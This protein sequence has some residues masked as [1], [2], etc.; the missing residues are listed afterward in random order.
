MQ[1]SAIFPRV[2]LGEV[3]AA[4]NGALERHFP[5]GCGVRIIAEPGRSDYFAQV[6][7]VPCIVSNSSRFRHLCKDNTE[8]CKVDFILGAKHCLAI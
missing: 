7:H 6:G 4:V 8:V 2:D 3:P 5:P 1:S